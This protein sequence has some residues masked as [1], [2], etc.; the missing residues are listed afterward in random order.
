MGLKT[1]HMGEI[2]AP[3]VKEKHCGGIM[4]L[5][6]LS[7]QKSWKQ[8][9]GKL[10]QGLV[11]KSKEQIEWLRVSFIRLNMKQREIALQILVRERT[12]ND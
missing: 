9:T 11:P 2:K 4:L 5:M 1:G 6:V 12:K 8:R 7:T 3:L 10:K